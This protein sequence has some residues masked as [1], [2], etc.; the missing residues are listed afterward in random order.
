VPISPQANLFSTGTGTGTGT[1]TSATNTE[2]SAGIKKKG[3]C[4]RVF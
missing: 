1:G 4:G 3:G 2:A